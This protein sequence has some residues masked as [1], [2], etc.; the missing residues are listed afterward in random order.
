MLA[1][2]KSVFRTLSSIYDGALLGKKK[3]KHKYTGGF[4]GFVQG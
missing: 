2:I 1:G 4:T 3:F